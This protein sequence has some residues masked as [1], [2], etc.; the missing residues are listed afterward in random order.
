MTIIFPHTMQCELCIGV[1][2]FLTALAKGNF[3]KIEL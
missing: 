2:G 1:G 3:N